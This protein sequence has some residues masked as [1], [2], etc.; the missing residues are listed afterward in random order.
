M[1]A[2]HV[3]VVELSALETLEAADAA[4]AAMADGSDA[5]DRAHVSKPAQFTKIVAKFCL[6]RVNQSHQ[7]DHVFNVTLYLLN[8][9][10]NNEILHCFTQK[11][12]NVKYKD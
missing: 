6:I 12:S 8:Q 11:Q 10:K 2:I 1:L 7:A 9:A 4:A 5:S 3:H